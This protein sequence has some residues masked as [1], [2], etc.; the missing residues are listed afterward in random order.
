[1]STNQVF[2]DTLSLAA[3]EGLQVSVLPKWYD[4]D[5]VRSVS[6]L[7]SDLMGTAPD[8]AVHTRRFLVQHRDIFAA[9]R[10]HFSEEN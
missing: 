4:V 5:D 6:R 7:M 3:E 9:A 1:M 8:I 2:A 10:D